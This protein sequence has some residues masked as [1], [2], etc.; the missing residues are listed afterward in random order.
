MA[1][2]IDFSGKR[3]LVTGGASGIGYG[4]AVAL[5]EA[6]AEVTI[7]ARSEESLAAC[8]TKTPYGELEAVRLDVADDKAIDT[9]LEDFG[10][11]DFLVNSAGTIVRAGGEYEIAKFQHVMDIN[12]TGTLRMCHAC[13]PK[14]AM[15]RGAVVNIASMMSYFAAPHA[16]AY[17]ASKTA[18]VSLTRSLAVAWAEHHVRINAIAPGWIDTKLARPALEDPDRGPKIMARLPM[19]RWGTPADM[20]GTAV[21]LCSP[22]AAYLTGVTIP[23]DGGY[24]AM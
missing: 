8:E 14:L 16:P 3:A 4:I 2:V 5:A 21:F 22:D 10:D 17:G 9:L 23:V 13:L 12:L 11:L 15:R 7:T 6:G 20:G 24:S 18:I 19:K 1:H